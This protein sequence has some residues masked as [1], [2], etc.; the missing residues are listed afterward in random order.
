ME[1]D[2]TVMRYFTVTLRLTV[3]AT[4]LLVCVLAAKQEEKWEKETEY[5]IRAKEERK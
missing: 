1:I 4:V 3:C 5:D 2:A